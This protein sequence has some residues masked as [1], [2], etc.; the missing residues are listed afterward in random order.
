MK[1]IANW[2]MSSGLA[3][4]LS[5]PEWLTPLVQGIHILAISAVIG[6]AL[7][8]C[9]RAFGLMRMDTGMSQTCGKMFPLFWGGII[10]A[11]VSGLV[12]V[13]G[14]PDRALMNSL[15]RIKMLVVLFG[16]VATLAVRSRVGARVAGPAE[17]GQFSSR[18]VMIGMVAIWLCVIALG[19]WIAYFE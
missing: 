4:A 15:F 5:G 16:V 10:L 6:A 17:N 3:A 11:A 18:L 12:L 19:R 9:L 2:V 13:L 8:I 1:E 14:Q 7:V